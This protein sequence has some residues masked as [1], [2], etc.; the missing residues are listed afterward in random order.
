MAAGSSLWLI[1]SFILLCIVSS[2]LTYTAYDI[3]SDRVCSSISKREL[4]LSMSRPILVRDTGR[5]LSRWPGIKYFRCKWEVE[6]KGHGTGVVGVIQLLKFRRSGY[7][8]CADFVE[9]KE[10]KESTPGPR[11][12]GAMIFGHYVSNNGSLMIMPPVM[13]S[14][15]P[16]TP[17]PPARSIIS[18]IFNRQKN[19][20]AG[21]VSRGSSI[22]PK[23]ELKTTVYVEAKPLRK[24]ETLELA[25]VFSGFV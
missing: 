14:P 17:P 12:C 10:D 13:P 6:S 23:G 8:E 2:A 11:L 25:I 19:Q 18:T 20:W 9:F 22:D 7:S 1:S 5:L 4:S 24:D 3:A 16:P 21:L 15:V